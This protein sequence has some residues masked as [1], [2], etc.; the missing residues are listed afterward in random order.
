VA[1]INGTSGNDT[2][3]GTSGDDTID[4]GLGNDIIDGAAGSDTAS[5]ADATAGVSVSLLLQGVAQDTV[6][7]GLDTL[8]NI[9]NLAG[10][11]YADTLTGDSAA[12]TLDGGA[13]DDTLDGGGGSDVLRGGAG[14][15]TYVYDPADTIIEK[16]GEGI[17][18]V[19]SSVDFTLGAYLER[20]TLTGTE[21]I[22]GTG[23]SLNNLMTGNSAANMLSGGD[24][25]DTLYGG[26]GDD[27]LSGGAGDDRLNGGDGN[28]LLEGG[29]GADTIDGGAGIDTV[30][31]ATADS[32]VQVFLSVT[33]PY[34]TRGGGYPERIINV[35]NVIGSDFDDQLSGTIG[36]NQIDG[37]AGND[38]ISGGQGDD[39]LTGG[40]GNDQFSYQA[41]DGKDT[42]T[43][44]TAGDDVA[45]YGVLAQSVTQV[46]SDVVVVFSA[47]DQLTFLN[48]DVATVENYLPQPSTF[49]QP[50]STIIP[51]LPTRPDSPTANGTIVASTIASDQ[52]YYGVDIDPT[53]GPYGTYFRAGWG[54][55]LVTGSSGLGGSVTNDGTIWDAS[56]K[57]SVNSVWADT[58]VNS[59]TIIAE[60]GPFDPPGSASMQYWTAR[61]VE[62]T[63]GSTLAA[64]IFSN[65]GSIYSIATAGGALGV[66]TSSGLKSTL[67]NDGLIAVQATYG[68]DHSQTGG[69]QGV[70][71]ENGGNFING[72]NGQIL[73]EGDGLAYGIYQGRGSHPAWD[74]GPEIDN[75][76]LIH[77]IVGPEAARP[78]VGIFAVNLPTELMRIVNSGTIQADIAIYCP[79]DPANAFT[80]S[81]IVNAQT[82]TNEAGG[83][84][85]GKIQ[86]ELGNDTLINAGTITGTVDMGGNND[87]VDNGAGVINGIVLLGDG[88]DTFTGG[89]S[90]DHARGGVGDDALT[91]GA[92][93]DLLEGDF[94]NDTLD[95][96]AGNDGLYG[97][98]GND[99]LRT[100]DADVAHGDYGD[101][102]IETADYG[103]AAIDGGVGYDQWVLP[104]GARMLDLGIVAA[105]GRVTGI[106]EIDLRGSQ[107]LVV[108]PADLTPIS[109]GDTLHLRGGSTDSVYLDGSWSSISSVTE[110]GVTY[111]GYQSGASIVLIES[112]VGVTI[113]TS[114]PAAGGLDA[115]SGGPSAPSPDAD[116]ETNIYSVSREQVL[117][118]FVIGRDET[119]LSPDGAN[120]LAFEYIPVGGQLYDA[121]DV[122]NYGQII[123][124]VGV[125]S[126]ASAVGSPFDEFYNFGTF[127]NFGT[128]RAETAGA[129]TD[130]LGFFGGGLGVLT[131]DGDIA[132]IAH[133]SGD[134]TGV[135]TFDD[136]IE[137][138]SVTNQSSGYIG[139]VSDF[140]YA[141]GVFSAQ[142]GSVVNDGAIEVQGATG[143][144]AVDQFN[145][146]GDLTNTG[147]IIAS[148]TPGGGGLSIGLAHDSVGFGG[149]TN[150]GL[151][152]A[153]IAV[154][155]Q[156]R[157]GEEFAINNSGTIE[158]AIVWNID[159]A[160]PTYTFGRLSLTNSGTIVGNIVAEPTS[161]G[162][163][164]IVNTGSITGDMYLY[165]GNDSYNGG[166]G[167]LQGFIDAGAGDD[168]LNGGASS[169]SFYGGDGNDTLTGNGGDDLLDGGAGDDGIKGGAGADTASYSDAS[170]G[171]TVS[172]LT[173]AAQDTGGAGLDTLNSI[174][175]LAGSSF[176]DR[177]TGNGGVNV[178]TGNA[179]DDVLNGGGGADTM[180]GGSGDDLYYVDN[181][182][183]VVTDSKFAGTD[184]VLASVSF[185]LGANFENLTLT[186]AAAINGT[187]NG[188]DN[189]I[190]GNAAVNTLDGGSGNDTLLGGGGDDV[191]IGGAGLD[192]LNGGAGADAMAGGTGSD[193]YYVDNALDTVSEN[194]GEGTDTVIASIDY[195]LGANVE[196][197]TLGGTAVNATG[198]GQAN[199]IRGDDL[200]NLLDGAAGADAMSGGKGNDT[201]IVDNVLDR[202]FEALNEGVDTVLSSVTFKLG[203]NVENLTLTGAGAVNGNGNA[204]DNVI[205]GN[206]AA[207]TLY[208]SAGSDSLTANGGNDILDGG[209]GAD[210]LAGGAGNDTYIVDNAL[211][212]VSESAGEGTDLVKSSVSWTLGAETENLTLLG[213]LAID[214]TGNALDNVISGNN[215]VNSLGGGGGNDTLWGYGGN[216]TLIG[217]A[218]KDTLIGGTGNDTFLFAGGDFGGATTV[219]ADRIT[220]FTGGQDKIDLTQLDANTLSGGDQA[221][222]FIG[223]AAFSGTAGELHY[224]QIGG[225]TYISGDTNGDG[226]A[227]FMIKLDGLH[228]LVSADFGL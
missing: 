100:A 63:A 181:A 124:D 97:G 64:Q 48:T 204:L 156:T 57:Y 130:A 26:D 176:G 196:E 99:V 80:T 195:V 208:G 173:T 161:T 123:N 92:G 40:S 12:N 168:S 160:E 34:D 86:L 105:S 199:T 11:V 89:A 184:T 133:G 226:L 183:D 200:D 167:T 22:N 126:V 214:G 51:L 91:S 155:F 45:I 139:A 138:P 103:F 192:K 112:G 62:V 104:T 144:V 35:E 129:S 114:P 28:D 177:L 166:Q 21:A 141:T 42:I 88:N 132:A 146:G 110:D 219:T 31:F 175:N 206:D 201:Y 148:I 14:N 9:E 212:T 50:P 72:V 194:A 186:G 169:D 153:D 115:I 143:A 198:N 207:N 90:A 202:A 52:V 17:D 187:G 224:Q 119:W 164:T 41:G 71:M 222:S 152:S 162:I 13:G 55:P 76:G 135:T 107:T 128:I 81:T 29:P 205:I 117:D 137:G 61:A 67:T 174:E 171:V 109:G 120:V 193:T 19:L 65:T 85:E 185:T 134:A 16:P 36:A 157:Y 213:A 46:G 30:S 6:A 220:D 142:A 53:F 190:T 79:S 38:S 82:V 98:T 37:G 209:T 43:D 49:T 68:S 75:R 182:G 96:G 116:A 69:A 33:W 127:S 56:T 163:E 121:P 113:G 102:R 150:S 111:A 94:G 136:E 95:G 151:I 145:A 218:G 5:Y 18:T 203:S 39:V 106:E 59:G 215:G 77:V 7:A 84:I 172:L 32:S 216:D 210:A 58:L 20:L 66:Y 197:L 149:L 125:G 8:T 178:L 24:G 131:N 118:D 228:T 217:G 87:V 159:D 122:V 188:G 189:A 227:D 154:Y 108:H 140:G 10:S 170:A 223:S 3:T 4:G 54:S 221:F 180:I 44:L 158:G 2:L 47:T 1:T 101:D 93:A 60:V 70:R 27:V 78:S 73:V 25:N 211:D 15:D 147:S 179:G 23:N 74:L 191:L 165:G 83:L 225:N